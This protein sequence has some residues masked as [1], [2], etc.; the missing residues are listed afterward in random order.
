MQKKMTTCLFLLLQHAMGERSLAVE[1][2]ELRPFGFDWLSL[3]IFKAFDTRGNVVSAHLLRGIRAT[4]T[5]LAMFN[6]KL[7]VNT[8]EKTAVKNDPKRFPEEKKKKDKE[9][10]GF[11]F[12]TVAPVTTAPPFHAE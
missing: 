7:Y 6:N 8:Q 10:F 11:T 4:V 2:L 9:I 12:Q 3:E 1:Q 5:G